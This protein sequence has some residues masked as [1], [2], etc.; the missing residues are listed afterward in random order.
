MRKILLE[1]P[2]FHPCASIWTS[3]LDVLIRA[4]L[5]MEGHQG[6]MT[7]KDGRGMRNTDVPS[8]DKIPK[9]I[10]F[11]QN[12]RRLQKIPHSHSYLKGMATRFQLEIFRKCIQK[13][14][15]CYST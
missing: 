11:G 9:P 7:P 10:C 2:I 4:K 1:S 5:E 12:S 13:R 8:S 14:A 3:S 15:S 6:Q